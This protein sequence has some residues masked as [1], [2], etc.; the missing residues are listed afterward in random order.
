MPMVATSRGAS[1]GR[2]SKQRMAECSIVPIRFPNFGRAGGGRRGERRG[3]GGAVGDSKR[4]KGG[5][6]PEE[7]KEIGGVDTRVGI[8]NS[9]GAREG[10]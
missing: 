4:R 1:R 6:V 10:G 2:S 8:L 9:G 5:E 3:D 7:G